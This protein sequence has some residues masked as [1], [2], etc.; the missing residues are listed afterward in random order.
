MSTKRGADPKVKTPVQA[1]SAGFFLLPAHWGVG[2]KFGYRT[3]WER[4]GV[5]TLLD[6]VGWV[7]VC[8]WTHVDNNHHVA[9][10]DMCVGVRVGAHA[11]AN[12]HV[13]RMHG[14]EGGRERGR[15]RASSPAERAFWEE[16]RLSQ[17][18]DHHVVVTTGVYIIA[19]TRTTS[20]NTSCDIYLVCNMCA[21]MLSLTARVSTR[22]C[23][24]T[25]NGLKLNVHV[26]V[27]SHMVMMVMI[28]NEDAIGGGSLVHVL[29]QKHH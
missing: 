2:R 21:C 13:G 6:R 17:P 29:Q 3:P 8:A 28:S 26:Q 19:V 4:D 18:H 1:R 20:V 7:L 25:T 22:P 9:G 11:Y 16:A 12:V 15:Q 10:K 24:S 23:E 14:W 5:A 27:E